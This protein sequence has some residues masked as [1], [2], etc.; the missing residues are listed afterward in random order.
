MALTPLASGVGTANAVPAPATGKR[1]GGPTPST[2]KLQPPLP[3]PDGKVDHMLLPPRSSSPSTLALPTDSIRRMMKRDFEKGRQVAGSPEAR[4]ETQFQARVEVENDHFRQFT[5]CVNKGAHACEASWNGGPMVEPI[6]GVV[7]RLAA[8]W[9]PGHPYPLDVTVMN[10]PVEN[11]FSVGGGQIVVNLGLLE[12]GP[13]GARNEHELAFIMAHELA[14]EFHQDRAG[15][16]QAVDGINGKIDEFNGKHEPADHITPVSPVVTDI[17]EIKDEI[18]R[19]YEAEADAT[20]LRMMSR[21]GFDPEQAVAWFRRHPADAGGGSHPQVVD[22]IAAA[23]AQIER[24]G[25]MEVYRQN[26]RP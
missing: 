1:I 21:A 15:M 23:E 20:A 26:R 6:Q 12:D 2:E 25:L 19:T 22:R 4:A 5:T 13:G 10:D 24:E 16:Q 18:S 7:D 17:Y 11:A 3:P 8:T 9:N 14:H